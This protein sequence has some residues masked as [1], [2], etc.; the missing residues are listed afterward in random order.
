MATK[1]VAPGRATVLDVVHTLGAAVVQAKYEDDFLLATARILYEHFLSDAVTVSRL[2]DDVLRVR[3][4]S[5]AAGFEMYEHERVAEG[6]GEQDSRQWLLMLETAF[7]PDVQASSLV[8]P[9]FKEHAQRLG[10]NT[11]LVV[12]LISEG[13]LLG[14]VSFG[15]A[16]TPE[17]ESLDRE[18]IRKLLDVV[19]KHLSFVH[20]RMLQHIDPL[21][22]LYNRLALE[23]HWPRESVPVRG[24]LLYMDLDGF[25][26]L[27]DARGH[28]A[29][30]EYLRRAAAELQEAAPQG[31]AVYR[32]G[33]DEFVLFGPG[34][35]AGDVD[36]LT[37]K[38]T[39]RFQRLGASL[40][41]PRPG[42]TIGAA[43]APEDGLEL[44]E[45]LDEADKRMYERK[46]QRAVATMLTTVDSRVGSGKSGA[47]KGHELK[48]VLGGGPGQGLS[49]NVF[50]GWLETWPDGI[51]VTD[52]DFKIIYVNRTYERIT[53]YTLEEWI[54]KSPGF[55]A[56]DGPRPGTYR[57]MWNSL[58]DKGAWS[59][60]AV[61]RRPDG[62]EWVA[63]MSIT[64]L[65]NES[66]ALVGYMGNAR[67]VS[68]SLWAGSV[69]QKNTFQEA[70]TQEALAFALAEAG[71]LHEGGSRQHLERIRDFTRLLVLGAADA[72][73]AELQDYETRNT[74]VLASILHDIGKLAIPEGLLR[75]PGRLTKE[76]FALVKTHTTAGEELL[77]SPHFSQDGVTPESSFLS[78]AA[79]IARSHHE[80]WDGSGYPDGLKGGDIPLGARI[81]GI[82]DVY[83]A[84]RSQRPYKNPWSHRETVE[85][86][87]GGA[88]RQFDPGLVKIFIDLALEFK[89]VSERALDEGGTRSHPAQ[90]KTG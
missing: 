66:G 90:G 24:V 18:Y 21:T 56:S 72:G 67:D 68:H 7:I 42:I 52:P 70:F 28:A 81:V 35:A 69:D 60:Q 5:T 84:L 78:M 88:G 43:Y 58:T 25:K 50:R 40:P 82:A 33:G 49:E 29:G 83:D 39:R 46:R 12:P 8:K 75:K 53:G 38:I 15:W 1:A 20:T 6:F 59:G 3:A 30:D 74:I 9:A 27:N 89:A 41:P 10:V 48:D 31:G 22:G 80:W 64:R 57:E 65:E 14:F 34:V 73:Y 87:V 17:S 62:V 44:D 2:E 61:N 71:Q 13:D 76:E 79:T 4:V 54:G 47:T 85:Y 86:I 77:R 55:I 63:S 32:L 26:A 19:A 51:I 23:H 16:E 11:E 37:D 36:R 45:L